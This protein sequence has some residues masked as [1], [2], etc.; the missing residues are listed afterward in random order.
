MGIDWNKWLKGLTLVSAMCA[1]GTVLA[2]DIVVTDGLWKVTYMES[3]K[4]FRINVL[5]EGGA[6]RKCV[7]NHSASAA[8]YDNA[9]GTPREVT[10]ASFA[11]VEQSVAEVDD[12]FGAGRCYTFTFTGPDNGDEVA[13]RQRFYIYPGRDYLLTDL[14]LV[15]DAGIRSNYLAP[16]S[17]DGGSY[18]LFASSD[19]NRMLRVPYDNDA[20]GR[21]GKCRMTGDV[22]SYEVS[23][24][25]AGESREGLVVGSVTHDIWKSAVAASLS[26]NG[27]VNALRVFSGVSTADTR[28]SIPHGKVKG[29]EV[30]SARMFVGY[31]DDWRTGM[32]TFAEANNLVAPRTESWTHGTPFG[33]QSWGVLAEKN[34]YDTDV[35]ISDYYHEVLTPGGFCNSQ[36]NIVFSL[37]ASDGMSSTEH[38]AFIRQCEEKNQIVGCYGTPFS[39]WSDENPNWDDVLG[40]AADGTQWRRRDVVLKADGKPIR[41]D[42]AYCMDPTHPYT[43]SAM[44]NFLRTQAAYGFRYV[45]MDFLNCGMVQADSYY[46]PEV[47]TAVAA[48]NEGMEYIRRQLDQWGMFAAFSI[49]PLF[50]HQ[51]ANSRRVACDTWGSIGHSEYCM[52][53]ISA[54]WWTDRLFQY[55]DPDHLVLVG[56]NEQLNNSIGENRARFTTGAVTGMMLVADN[57]SLSDRS[58]RGWAERSREVAQTVMLNRDINEMADLGRS[59][60]PVYGYKE[61]NGNDDGAENFFMLHTDN[62]LYVAAFNYEDK[63][64]RGEIP[65]ELLDIAAGD[66]SEVRELWTNAVVDVAGA[67]PYHV[68]G[69]DARVYRFKKTHG[70]GIAGTEQGGAA[71]LRVTALGGGRLMAYAGKAMERIEAFDL[72]GRL[73][74]AEALDRRT[75]VAVS[76]RQA[77]GMALVRVRYADGTWETCKALVR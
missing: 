3:E 1:G 51:Y 63:D 32:E 37:D 68:P 4:A 39:M 14:S 73:L 76:L 41:L 56:A 67:L 62:Y 60:R 10:T 12:A 54:G 69:E 70:S 64:L 19:N 30:V 52:N 57:F 24:L 46:N 48:Y 55:N 66:F 31:F 27:T 35:E 47:T 15:G 34:S 28:D 23:A 61:Y 65:L 33:W 2:D 38:S 18:V 74:T 42:G 72:Q 77:R 16:V 71:G 13:M 43:K 59:F 26:N 22:L 29:P 17:V 75:Q 5:D 49:A 7:V 50:P 40:Q 6:A 8:H 44:A 25:Y 20:F 58:G 45:K 53:A 36:G 11:T 21:Y 9:G